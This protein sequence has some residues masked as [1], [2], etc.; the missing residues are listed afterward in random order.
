MASAVVYTK[1]FE[2]AKKKI[3]ESIYAGLTNVGRVLHS[4]AVMNIH[5]NGSIDSGRLIN[6]MSYSIGGNTFGAKGNGMSATVTTSNSKENVYV[7]TSVEYAQYVEFG[8]KFQ[9]AKSFLRSAVASEQ[10]DFP[11]IIQETLKVKLDEL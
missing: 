3:E 8:T 10:K 11:K 5:K 4:Q 1:K 6:S 9:R 7:G 2:K